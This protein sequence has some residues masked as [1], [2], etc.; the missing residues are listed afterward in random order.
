M[1]YFFDKRS[2]YEKIIEFICI[3]KGVKR[4]DIFKILKN[5]EC[6]YLLFLLLKRYNCIDQYML[7]KDFYIEDSDINKYVNS[8]Q[9][10]MLANIRVRNMYF[11]AEGILEKCKKISK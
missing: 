1:K 6:R 11:E 9:K 4:Q 5:I 2:R 3:Y 7:N 10:K 8:A